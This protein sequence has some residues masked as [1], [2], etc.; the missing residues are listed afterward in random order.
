MQSRSIDSYVHAIHSSQQFDI[1]AID[2]A[3]PI[4]A[5]KYAIESESPFPKHGITNCEACHVAGAYEVPNQSKS[6]P[7]I[8]SASAD[9]LI[10]KTRNISGV[11]SY[12]VG[13]AARACGACHRAALINEDAAKGLGLFNRHLAQFGY[14]VEAGEKPLDTLDGVFEQIMELFK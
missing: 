3:N 4:F 14:M 11:P 13:P 10:G 9:K 12:V 7:G 1:A 2:F 6:M 8:L 5:E